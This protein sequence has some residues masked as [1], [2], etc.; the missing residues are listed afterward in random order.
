M[1]VFSSGALPFEPCFTRWQISQPETYFATSDFTPGHH[2]TRTRSHV[3]SR[4]MCLEVSRELTEE[5]SDVD[6]EEVQQGDSGFSRV[7]YFPLVDPCSYDNVEYHLPILS[8]DRAPAPFTA[9]RPLP[10][11][12]LGPSIP[13]VVHRLLGIPLPLDNTFWRHGHLSSQA[14]ATHLGVMDIFP[15]MDIFPRWTT[16]LGV[17]DIFPRKHGKDSVSTVR[18]S[19]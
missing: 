1:S 8:I 15:Y 6:F 4:P 10:Q 9:P 14:W 19:G 2:T 5:T 12:L 13:V 11:G 3:R 17:M 18:F 16:H 7:D